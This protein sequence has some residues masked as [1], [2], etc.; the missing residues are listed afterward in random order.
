MTE[1]QL[2][3]LGIDA[4]WNGP[5]DVVFQKYNI[6]TPKR[7]AA[8]IG[9]CSVESDNFTVLQENLHY[10]AQRLTEVWPSRFPNLEQA[11]PY[12]ENPVKLADKV[13]GGRDGNTDDG[14]GYK[15]RGR[16]VIQVTFKDNYD[17]CGKAL[18]LD[19]I[20]HPDFLLEPEFAALSAGWYWNKMGLNSLADLGDNKEITKRINGGYNGL[21]E[22]ITKTNQALKVLG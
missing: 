6:N 1:A 14:D 20:N 4:K 3:E 2:R 8:F 19:L 10:S 15:Y 16:G 7:Q 22:R 17:R 11:Q 9:Q 5:L 21:S 13:Y 18:G 12:A